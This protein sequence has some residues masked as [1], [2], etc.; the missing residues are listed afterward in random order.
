[1]KEVYDGVKV[2][3]KETKEN[4]G[5]DY[6]LLN[7]HE[8]SLLNSFVM[9]RDRNRTKPPAMRVRAEEAVALREK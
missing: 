4:Y 6:L 1:M 9:F 5:S 8:V 2:D 3:K 7:N